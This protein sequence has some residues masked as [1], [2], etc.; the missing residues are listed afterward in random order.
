MSYKYGWYS[1]KM[2]EHNIQNIHSRMGRKKSPISNIYE[3]TD[4]KE[5]EVTV[6]S[7]K[8]DNY[9]CVNIKSF[10]DLVYIGELKCYVRSI[11]R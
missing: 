8:N 9:G 1:K 5:V 6:V 3:R 7:D 10:P 11:F 4:G 2:K